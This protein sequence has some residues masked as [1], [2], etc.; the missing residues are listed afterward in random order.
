MNKKIFAIFFL[1][2]LTCLLSTGCK[3]EKIIVSF[4]SL[5]GTSVENIEITKNK[6]I[7]KPVDPVK[8]N[9]LFD[10]WYISNYFVDGNK[11]NFDK[12]ITNNITLYA[13]WNPKEFTIN[14]DLDGGYFEYDP[15]V[16]FKTDDEVMLSIPKKE[17]HIFLGWMENGNFIDKIENRNYDLTAVW[18]KDAVEV[19]FIVDDVLYSKTNVKVN[20]T[21]AYPHN[22]YKE[23]YNFIG[24]YLNDELFDNTTLLTENIE[25]IAKFEKIQFKVIFSTYSSYKIDEIYVGYG[26]TFILPTPIKDGYDFTG[27]L[28]DEMPFVENTKVYSNILLVATWEMTKETMQEEL[29]K[30]IPQQI[31]S[32]LEFVDSI[33]GS[34]AMLFWSSSNEKV[35][36]NDGTVIRTDKDVEVTITVTVKYDNYEYDLNFK[37]VVLKSNLKP[38]V[39]GEIVST[40]CY[41]KLKNITSSMLEQLDIIN[42]SFASIKDGKVFIPTSL[43]YDEVAYCH[44]KGVRVI[45]AIGGWGAGGFSEA[46]RTEATRTILIESIMDAIKKY[47]FDGI[48]IDWEYPTSSVAGIVSHPSD[49]ANLNLFCEEMKQSMVEYRSDLLLTIATNSS[50]S[51]YDFAQLNN[52]IDLFNLMTYDF[53]MGTVAHHDSA[54]YTVSGASTAS[55]H[56]S[57]STV[58]MYVNKN[59]I[60]PGVAMYARYGTFKSDTTPMLGNIFGNG[61]TM[62]SAISYKDLKEKYLLNSIFKEYYDEN[63]EAAYGFYNQTFYSYDNPRSIF[64]KASYV[65]TK[66]YGGL[67]AWDISQDYVDSNG[68]GELLNAMYEGLKG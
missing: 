53:A 6:T 4:D 23:G 17:N 46:M 60:V 29:S 36:T 57:I 66:G 64:A 44:E 68:Y 12:K 15:V 43:T 8:E 14:Y 9:Y 38:I 13:K 54:L 62:A 24:W 55:L 59:K 31:I 61:A 18:V 30:L 1:L 34:A 48:D 63:A 45:L 11:F 51:F 49:R 16:L 7:S 22:P 42:Y 10:G 33:R 32:S 40:Y 65:K 67:M 3:K 56:S 5:G 47:Q 19:K 28:F 2:F 26:E 35:I 41:G 20:S 58:S 50:N 25:L 21:T 39:K 37:T 27:W 52:Y